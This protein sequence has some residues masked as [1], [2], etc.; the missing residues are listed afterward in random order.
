MHGQGRLARAGLGWQ[1][2]HKDVKKNK[3]VRQKNKNKLARTAAGAGLGD[4]SR[5][6]SFDE[7]KQIRVRTKNNSGCKKEI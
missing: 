6:K 2:L 7:A 3:T 4:K 1:K 5:E